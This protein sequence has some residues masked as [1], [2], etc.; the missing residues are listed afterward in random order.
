[1]CLSVQHVSTL[2]TMILPTI[3]VTFHGLDC[4]NHLIY[5]LQ[6]STYQNIAKL[7]TH[8]NI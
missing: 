8:S 1:M 2:S 7:L 4:F 5:K 3:A 6:T